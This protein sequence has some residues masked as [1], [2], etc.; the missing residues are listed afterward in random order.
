[1]NEV[2]IELITPDWG[3]L[4][5]GNSITAIR[6]ARILKRLGHRVKM[7]CCYDG[8]PCDLMIALHARRSHRSIRLFRKLYPESPLIL[9]LTGTDL[10]R[11]IRGN[12]NAQESLLMATRLVVLQKM[13]LT[14]LP[15]AVRDKAEVIYQ[16]A[17]R[18]RRLKPPSTYFKVC[19]IGNL[20]PEKDPLRAAIAAGLLPASS[21]LKVLHAGYPLDRRLEKLAVKEES[22]NNR[23]R[24]LGELPHW[25]VRQLIASSHLVAVTSLIEGSS[26]VLCEALAS[27]VPVI[28]SEISGL[29]GT[30]GE[31]YPGYF[32]AGDTLACASLLW[33]AESDGSFYKQ[34]EK[35][36]LKLA[37][38]V[39][40]ERELKS[41]KRLL[42]PFLR[43]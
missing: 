4:P 13:G 19:V 29:V 14:E 34:L 32:P 3:D 31:D 23:Y 8:S 20:R 28:A 24:W 33:R 26:N 37:R 16:S 38:L 25:K 21:R 11:D 22:R 10:Y 41:W 36:C 39:S 2:R 18:V 12:T 9:V 42:E 6:Y 5:S 1:L 35:R 27:S 30:L 43:K 15:P 7:A 17:E 40:P